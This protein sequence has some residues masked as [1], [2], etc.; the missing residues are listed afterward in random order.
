M[1]RNADGLRT[2]KRDHAIEDM[3]GDRD[4]GILTCIGL[5]TQ[6][7]ANDLLEP[8]NRGLHR[9]SLLSPEAFCQPM[10]PRSAMHLDDGRAA[11]DRSWKFRAQP[12][13]SA[14]AR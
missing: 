8:A 11:L 10:R 2:S 3:D 5:R 1:L 14:A 12:Q 6:L 9:R 7:V 13:W 4:L